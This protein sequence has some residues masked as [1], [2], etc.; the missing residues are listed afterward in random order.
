M[1]HSNFLKEL[2]FGNEKI[3]LVDVV[4]LSLENSGL[5]EDLKKKKSSKDVSSKGRKMTPL[6]KRKHVWEFWHT[7]ATHST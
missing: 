1:K 4:L 2:K 3:N 5:Y 6:Y 7:N